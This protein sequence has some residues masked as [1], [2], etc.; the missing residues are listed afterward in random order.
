MLNEK[1]RLIEEDRKILDE[2]DRIIEE[3]RQQL[4][5]Q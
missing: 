3:L 2:K 1:D 5:N 4:K